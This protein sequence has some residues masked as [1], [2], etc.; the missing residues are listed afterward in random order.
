MTKQQLI[1][2]DVDSQGI[3]D[4]YEDGDEDQAI[5]EY[6]DAA[7]EIWRVRQNSEEARQ[8]LKLQAQS[9]HRKQR[10]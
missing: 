5:D 4:M 9:N 6:I 8:A 7:E 10:S 2:L 3:E 1:R